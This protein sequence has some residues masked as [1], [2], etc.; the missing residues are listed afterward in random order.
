MPRS[1]GTAPPTPLRQ[2]SVKKNQTLRECNIFSLAKTA[3]V[4]VAVERLQPYKPKQSPHVNAMNEKH[5]ASPLFSLGIS[6]RGCF[7]FGA[8]PRT[9]SGNTMYVQASR[10]SCKPEFAEDHCGVP[11]SRLRASQV[12][13]EAIF[14]SF[15][16]PTEPD[17]LTVTLQLNT[18]KSCCC[19][20][21]AKRTCVHR[22]FPT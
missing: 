12:S 4:V 22:V 21:R 6:P 14:V 20:S 13:P 17:Q 3:V 9:N 15:H 10:N 7:C 16:M 18:E 2:S 19:A 8:V 11:A 1:H 5:T